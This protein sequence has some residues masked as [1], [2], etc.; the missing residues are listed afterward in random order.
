VIAVRRFAPLLV[1]L[2]VSA[3]ASLGRGDPPNVTVAGIRTLQGEGFEMRML[4]KLRVQNPN[5]SA[6]DYNGV[7]VKFDVAGK[8]FATGVSDAAGT[9]PRFGESVIEVPVTISAMNMAKQ[10]MSVVHSGGA[11]MPE[12]IDYALTGK[13][14]G[15]MFNSVHFKSSG[16]LDMPTAPAGAAGT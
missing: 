15:S 8:T 10:V 13:L 9:V 4:V 3:C 7:S 1:A 16:T 5:D 12:K 11:K 6:I 2:A 14:S